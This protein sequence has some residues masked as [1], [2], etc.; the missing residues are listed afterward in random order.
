MQK[1]QKKFYGGNRVAHELKERVSFLRLRPA[2]YFSVGFSWRRHQITFKILPTDQLC[3][4]SQSTGGMA[5]TPG[6]LGQP[7]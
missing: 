4:H 3:R 5:V 7:L 2:R 6:Q 1:L